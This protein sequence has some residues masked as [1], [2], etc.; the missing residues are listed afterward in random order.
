MPEIINKIETMNCGVA[1]EPL[2]VLKENGWEYELSFHSHFTDQ[3][4]DACGRVETL[5]LNGDWDTIL[6]N[7]QTEEERRDGVA[8][9]L[10]KKTAQRIAWEKE[11]TQAIN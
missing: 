9:L 11:Q 4:N 10:K 8:Y 7:G 3:W 2:D 5:Q 6:V 1:K